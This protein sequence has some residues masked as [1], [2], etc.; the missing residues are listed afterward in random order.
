MTRVLIELKK[1]HKLIVHDQKQ[2]EDDKKWYQL[3]RKETR[4]VAKT[5]DKSLALVC[6]KCF[7]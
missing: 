3:A 4:Q 6:M 2:I 7:G 5:P 1:L